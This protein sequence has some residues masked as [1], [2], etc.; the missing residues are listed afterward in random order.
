MALVRASPRPASSIQRLEQGALIDAT[1]LRR[2]SAWPL[3]RARLLADR[4]RWTP[5]CQGGEPGAWSRRDKGVEAL[6]RHIEGAGQRS[7]P[8]LR[9]LKPAASGRAAAARVPAGSAASLSCSIGRV[10]RSM[11]ANTTNRVGQQQAST[12]GCLSRAWPT[13]RL[14]VEQRSDDQRRDRGRQRGRDT[15]SRSLR[16]SLVQLP[17]RVRG[18]GD[19]RRGSW[20]RCGDIVVCRTAMPISSP[21]VRAG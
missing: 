14:R 18:L 12:A 9:S 20:G 4:R 13:S 11:P 6:R 15:R 17:T 21:S 5:L 3:R 16:L 1:S 19:D 7:D 2:C 10:M 8:S